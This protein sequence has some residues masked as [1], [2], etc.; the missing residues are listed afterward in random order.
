MGF[1]EN[2]PYTN[3]HE[4]N[5]DWVIKRVMD[6]FKSS[7]DAVETANATKT[8]FEN[9]ENN[10]DVKQLVDSKLESMAED[11]SLG[12]AVENVPRNILIIGDSYGAGGTQ[13]GEIYTTY[14]EF[15]K[16][17]AKG[18]NIYS[19]CWSGA[20]FYGSGDGKSFRTLVE[21]FDEVDKSLITDII[22]CGG[23]NDRGQDAAIYTN[24]ANIYQYCAEAY[25]SAKLYV[26]FVGW[27]NYPA[28]YPSIEQARRVYNTIPNYGYIS[29][30]NYC[31]RNMSYMSG[32]G[33]HP[34]ATGQRVISEQLLNWISGGDVY[35]ADRKQFG[36][37][38]PYT[39]QG[40]LTQN[41]TNGFCYMDGVN[42]VFVGL[43]AMNYS[44]GEFLDLT[45]A[46]TDALV[47]NEANFAG[48]AVIN[49]G[50]VV[51]QRAVTLRYYNGKLQLRKNLYGINNIDDI[52]ISFQCSINPLI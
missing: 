51:E 30:I 15:L 27:S 23:Y 9:W 28:E 24:A 32:D 16:R 31:L 39:S 5:L 40:L 7:N 38:S 49:T 29:N 20:G 36:F 6:A 43:G 19:N 44:D 46:V 41:F 52:T 11:G 17:A 42:L 18:V 14:V 45:N 1:W 33:F 4:I 3:F 21:E 25:S 10:V 48:V 47:L 12:A 2:F 50:S 8:A 26:A 13:T 37:T 22:F 34:N 35:L